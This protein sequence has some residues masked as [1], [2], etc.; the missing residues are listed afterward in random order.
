MAPS[1]G[2]P[3]GVSLPSDIVMETESERAC[4]ERVTDSVGVGILGA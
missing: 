4:R 1:A 3:V 2:I